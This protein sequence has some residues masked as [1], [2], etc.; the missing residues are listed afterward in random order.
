[1]PNALETNHVRIADIDGYRFCS[2]QY[3]VGAVWINH[4]PLA[5]AAAIVKNVCATD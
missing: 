5:D 2:L 3:A 4:R 1:M